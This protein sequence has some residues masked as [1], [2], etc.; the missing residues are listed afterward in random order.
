VARKGEGL[1]GNNGWKLQALDNNHNH[2]LLTALSALPQ[3]RIAAMTPE[4]QAKVK[5]MNSENHSAN[6]I[7]TALQNAN[8]NSM[9]IPQ[10]IYNLLAGLCIDKL[11]GKTPIEWLLEKLK[12]KNFSPKEYTNPETHI[13]ECL[14]FAHP[15]AI[16]IYKEHPNIILIDCTYKTNHFRMPL[17]NICAVTGNKKTI[18]VGLCFLSGEKEGDYAWA[19]TAFQELMTEHSIREPT[20]IV[21]DRELALMNCLDCDGLGMPPRN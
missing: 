17:L 8:P 1:E 20:T 10:D 2:S 9:L 21:T 15:E 12:G 3:Y 5:Q 7:L 18:Q 16:A 14:F 11:A 19:V 13:L 4:E 6:Q